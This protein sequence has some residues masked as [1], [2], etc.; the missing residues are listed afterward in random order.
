VPLV[1]Q[2]REGLSCPTVVCDYCQ[3]P[4]TDARDGGYFFATTDRQ[5]GTTVPMTF[6]HK[7]RC[8]DRYSAQHGRLENWNELAA[9]PGYLAENLGLARKTWSRLGA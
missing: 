4:I 8:D 7:I 6:L 9:L 2:F 1:I 3:R 5:E